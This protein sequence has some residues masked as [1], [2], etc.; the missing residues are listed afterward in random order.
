MNSHLTKPSFKSF[1]AISLAV[2][3]WFT[4]FLQLY[5]TTESISNF[6]SY[7]TILCNLLIAVS[8]TIASISPKSKAGIFFSS[9]SVQTAIALY[10]FIVSLVY[11]LVLR[12]IWVFSGWQLFVDNMLHVV[13]PILYILFWLFFRTKGTLKW[14]DGLYWIVFPL[15]YLIYSLIRGSLINWYPYPFLNAAK[16]GYTKVLANISIMLIVFLVAG[17]IL[18]FITQSIKNKKLVETA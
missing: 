14:Q 7:F 12:G 1:S 18:I 2:I 9:L 3:T 8:L 16:L 13:N 17:L 15:S 10:I 6:F 4:I 5:L 11:N